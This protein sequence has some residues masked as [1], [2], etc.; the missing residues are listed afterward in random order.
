MADNKSVGAV[1]RLGLAQFRQ[2]LCTIGPAI[3]CLGQTTWWVLPI[4]ALVIVAALLKAKHFTRMKLAW[5]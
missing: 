2:G 5:C 4:A 1:G 3:R